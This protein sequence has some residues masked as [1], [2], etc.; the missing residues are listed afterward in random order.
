[1]TKKPGP[2]RIM[3]RAEGLFF[4]CRECGH[5]I[6]VGQ[7]RREA[8]SSTLV[9]V[10]QRTQAAAAMQAHYY[11]QHPNPIHCVDPMKAIR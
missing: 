6:D 9:R 3:R 1:M 5:E 11:Q 8:F 2:Y 7:F 10:S 4:V